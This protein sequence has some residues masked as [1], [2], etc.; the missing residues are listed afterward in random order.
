MKAF[1]DKEANPNTQVK[2]ITEKFLDLFREKGSTMSR[3]SKTSSCDSGKEKVQQTLA[4]ET[5]KLHGILKEAGMMSIVKQSLIEQN[6]ELKMQVLNIEQAAFEKDKLLRDKDEE[7]NKLF[8]LNKTLKENNTTL[9]QNTTALENKSTSLKQRINAL[10][11]EKNTLEQEKTALGHKST[12]LE[13]INQALE[14]EINTL[15]L[16]N[17]IF[18][19]INTDLE[20]KRASLEEKSNFLEQI[21]TALTLR[22]TSLEQKCTILENINTTLEQ[23]NE[24]LEQK[25]TDLKNMN[26]DLQLKLEQLNQQP[27]EQKTSENIQSVSDQPQKP[28]FRRVIS[29]VSNTFLKMYQ[30]GTLRYWIDIWYF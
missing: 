21:N 17:T 14:R 5:P 29:G 22:S 6:E 30:T 13:H 20:Q 11:K 23:Q 18:N 15:E 19:E 3:S 26:T 16:E 27:P 4:K 28:V 2:K 25:N 1:R 8:H 12:A 9:E 10:K 24:V 7:L